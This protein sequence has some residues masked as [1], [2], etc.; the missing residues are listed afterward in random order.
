VAAAW[1]AVWLAA[2][3]S[4]A[5]QNPITI[6][7]IVWEGLRRIPRDTMNARILSKPG[8]PYDPNL[9]QRDFQ[10]VWNTNFFEDVRLEVE[11]GEKGKAIYFIVVER[12]LIRR[13][14]YSGVNSVQQSDILERFRDRRVGLTVE[15]QYDPT[16]VRQAEVV[17]KELLSEHGRHFAKVGHDLRRVPP[18]AVILVFVVEEGPKVK[19][20]D[21]SFTGNRYFSDQK[22]RRA[23]K[24]SRP[25]GI[26]PWINLL[27]KTYNGAKVQEDLE[28]V[29]EIYQ[30]HGF[31]R[32]VVYPPETRTRGTEPWWPA[33]MLH[34][35]FKSGKA[36]DM[37]IRVEEGGRYR[38]GDLTVKSATGDDADLGLFTPEGLKLAFPLQRGDIFDVKKIRKSLEDYRKLFGSLG[39]INMTTIPGTDIDDE[40]RT[41]DLTLEFEPGKQFFVHRIEFAGNTTTRDKVIRRELLLEEGSVF[42]SEYWDYS[43][44]RLNQLG[45]FEELRPES[46]EV[47]Q[48]A[49]EG[50]VDI[51][52]KV[53]EKGKNSIGLSGGAS[54]V[55]G[56]FIGVDYS[57]NNFLGL[58]ET[59]SLNLE[60]G[61]RQQGFV[62]GF[63]EPYLFDRPLQTGFTFFLRRYEFDQLRE[64]SFTTRANSIN[65]ILQERLL[66]FTQ[67]TIGFSVFGSY[68]L[69]RWRYTRVG[70][71]YGYDVSDISCVTEGC[72]NLFE[73]LRF[74]SLEGPNTLEGIR[75]SRVTPT[76]LYNST[77]HPIFATRGTSV[78][79][80][81]TFEGGPIGGNQKSIRPTFEIKHYRPINAGRNTLAFRFLGAMVTGYGNTVPSPFVR[82]YTGGEDSIRGFDIR[83]ISPLVYV[84]IR[85]RI[86]FV[87][88]DPTHPD[89][90]GNPTVRLVNVDVL[91]RT[92]SFPGGDTQLLTNFEYRI[93]IAGPVFVSPFIDVGLNTILRR[94]QLRLSAE[95]FGDLQLKFPGADI[96]LDLELVPGTN[97]QIRASTGI[98][99]VINVPVLNAPFRIYWAYN[100][101][102]LKESIFI[103]GANRPCTSGVLACMKIPETDENGNPIFIDPGILE[104]QVIP[105]LGLSFQERRIFFSEP[106]KTF[107][108]TISR[109]F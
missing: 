20:G 14:E 69:K 76:W 28:R 55:S 102:R 30:E 23:M 75:S 21:I 88:A 42:N 48:N 9:L 79:L 109:T 84:P 57:T 101:L 66:N 53:K 10:A 36:V 29:R 4:L 73:S 37:R 7:K 96:P 52:L 26:P 47:Q 81:L 74:R 80:G 46:A 31:F 24:G 41:I 8:D 78:F 65:P 50:T 49:D 60:F 40:S 17:L 86:P 93:P 34:W 54:G 3:Y 87:F 62:F 22:L 106:A 94:S 95:N 99:L 25:Y 64:T 16:K 100:P 97:R 32:V 107:R 15:T 58:G 44:K 85:T 104:T 71:T 105:R 13:I 67:N 108:F 103:P 91:S 56:S 33:S 43:I 1:L 72:T 11:D 83:A 18:N 92:V 63:T 39:Y 89:S 35:W 5:A 98:E 27:A 68:P 90:N 6:E 82:F 70:L 59:L 77:N 51:T 38:M 19:V 12:P 2:P 61:D 45:Y